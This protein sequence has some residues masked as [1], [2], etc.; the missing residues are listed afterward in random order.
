MLKRRWKILWYNTNS[1]LGLCFYLLAVAVVLGPGPL[2]A[3][4]ST[5][6]LLQALRAHVEL[7]LAGT[8]ALKWILCQKHILC[9]TV[10]YRLGNSLHP[11]L[12]IVPW[13]FILDSRQFRCWRR[14]DRDV[15]CRF[16]D[17]LL[18]P[19]HSLF[20][21]LSEEHRAERSFC[22]KPDLHR[23]Q[24]VWWVL[25]MLLGY[26]AYDLSSSSTFVQHVAHCNVLGERLTASRNA[27]R[28]DVLL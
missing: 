2:L 15:F 3:L 10:V 16:T 4:R 8:P 1:H 11:H 21:L 18:N 13:Q 7:H 28:R 23:L 5:V 17:A 27:A 6:H 25:Q 19:H 24:L 9:N 12:N 20:S 14:N 22:P 26:A